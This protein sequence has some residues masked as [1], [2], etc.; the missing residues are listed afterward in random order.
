MKLTKMQEVMKRD[1]E[2]SIRWWLPG[3]YRLVDRRVRKDA[4]VKK[5]KTGGA[6]NE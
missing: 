5:T 3:N 4:G 1:I 6:T 2:R